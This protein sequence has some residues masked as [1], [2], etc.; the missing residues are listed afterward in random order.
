MGDYE[1]ASEFE[2]RLWVD[3]PQRQPEQVSPALRDQVRWMNARNLRHAARKLGEERKLDP[4]AAARLS[5]IHAPALVIVG[6]LDQPEMIDIADL[7]AGQIAGAH[8]MVMHGAAHVPSMEQ[9]LAFN[10]H[11]LDWLRRRQA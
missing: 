4:P 9:P 3:G 7:L 11:V 6:D 5:E 8:K 1:R 2:V 10:R